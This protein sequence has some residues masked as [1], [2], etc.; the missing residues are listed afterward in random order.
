MDIIL[1]IYSIVITCTAI[2]INI[3]WYKHCQKNNDEWFDIATDINKDWAELAYK[4]NHSWAD[5]IHQI[6]DKEVKKENDN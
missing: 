6:L 2:L 1:I 3:A 5:A 4:I